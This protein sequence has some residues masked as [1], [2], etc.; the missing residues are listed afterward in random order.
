M[1]ISCESSDK[2]AKLVAVPNNAPHELDTVDWA[3]LRTLAFDGRIPNSA[4][5]EAVGVAPSTCLARVRSLRERGVIRG[6]HADIDLAA[7]GLPLQALIA[8][9]LHSHNREEVDAFR[10]RALGLPGVLSVFHV[11]GVDDYLLHV[12]AASPD[13]L[14]DFVLDYLTG[15]PVV[16]HAQTSL[17]FEHV[18]GSAPFQ[19]PAGG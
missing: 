8:V 15:H 13:A 7:L 4:L 6:F 19:P 1:Q 12:A 14:R 3:I 11:A 2:P 10:T 17:I 9:R 5:A 18:R 16:Q